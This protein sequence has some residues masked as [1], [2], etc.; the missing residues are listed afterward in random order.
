MPIHT[1]NGA[2]FYVNIFVKARHEFAQLT[3]FVGIHHGD[4]TILGHHNR[5]AGL[6]FQALRAMNDEWRLAVEREQLIYMVVVCC[7]DRCCDPARRRYH[8]VATSY[9]ETPQAY[10]QSASLLFEIMHLNRC[11]RVTSKAGKAKADYWCHL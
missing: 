9:L 11:C 7:V 4:R 10:V 5:A 6:S 3:I 8:D 1:P 2:T